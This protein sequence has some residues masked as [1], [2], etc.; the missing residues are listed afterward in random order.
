MVR[1][2]ASSMVASRGL[3]G[4]AEAA[5]LKAINVARGQG[6]AMLALR[7]AVRLGRLPVGVADAKANR[8]LLRAARSVVATE[9]RIADIRDA[10][11]LLLRR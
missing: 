11:A 6:A 2:C 4:D 8:E 7:A 5:F 1:R 10:D 9:S 3:A